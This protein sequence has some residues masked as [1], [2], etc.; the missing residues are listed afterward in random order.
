MTFLSLQDYAAKKMKLCTLNRVN[1]ALEM[2]N[3]AQNYALLVIKKPLF[4]HFTY[5]SSTFFGN[6]VEN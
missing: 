3:Y 2:S 6:N 1:C 5:I 4:H